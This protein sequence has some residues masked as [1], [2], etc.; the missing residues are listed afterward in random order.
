MN[1][2]QNLI[3]NS[4][5]FLNKDDLRR[6]CMQLTL[7]FSDP[8]LHIAGTGVDAKALTTSAIIN[9][10]NISIFA[11]PLMKEKTGCQMQRKILGSHGIW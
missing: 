2:S 3:V 5:A 10:Y 8:S 7:F 1:L 4:I 9:Q 11:V 6:N